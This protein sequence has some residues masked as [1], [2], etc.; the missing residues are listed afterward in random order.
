MSK[1]LAERLKASR[2]QNENPSNPSNPQNQP[3]QGPTVEQQIAFLQAQNRVLQEQL[4]LRNQENEEARLMEQA[5]KM[6][7]EKAQLTE[8]ANLQKVLQETFKAKTPKENEE[9]GQLDPRELLEVMAEAVGRSLDAQS[10]LLRTE[11]Q[12]VVGSQTK[13]VKNTQQA[14]MELIGT[15]SLKE[16][17]SQFQDF[18]QHAEA[19][20]AILLRHPTLDPQRAYLL[21]KAEASSQAPA[22]PQISSERPSQTPPYLQMPSSKENEAIESEQ[23]QGLSARQIFRAAASKAIDDVL[24]RRQK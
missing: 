16:T 12:E 14:L 13:D 8:E 23:P 10:K 11:M 17:R 20:K 9:T 21:A 18:D 5:E 19:V 7:L 22:Q 3:P 15:L 2:S 4:Q 1:E 24:A 6:K